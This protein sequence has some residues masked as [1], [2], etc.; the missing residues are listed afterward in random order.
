MLYD[1]RD[2]KIK[3]IQAWITSTDTMTGT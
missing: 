3:V 2:I 1:K